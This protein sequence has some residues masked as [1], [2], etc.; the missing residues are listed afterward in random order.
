MLTEKSKNNRMQQIMKTRFIKIILRVIIGAVFIV[1][2]LE[3][4]LQPE[5]FSHAIKNYHLV[6]AGMVNFLALGIPMTELGAGVCLLLGIKPRIM[7]WV[8]CLFLLSFLGAIAH[9]LW[10]G[11]PISCGCFLGDDASI[12]SMWT[13]FFRDCVLLAATLYM[14]ALHAVPS[15]AASLNPAKT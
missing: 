2:G 5:V 3:K 8:I 12:G 14:I 13:S 7:G 15:Q 6:P 1:A 11:I 4:V 10:V 9:A